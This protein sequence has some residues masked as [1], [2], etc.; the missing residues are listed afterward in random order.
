MRNGSKKRKPELDLELE[1][2]LHTSFVA[3]ANSLSALYTNAISQHKKAHAQGAQAVLERQIAWL[4]HEYGSAQHVPLD[5][6][7][8]YLQHELQNTDALDASCAATA[9]T[10]QTFHGGGDVPMHQDPAPEMGQKASSSP[11]LKSADIWDGCVETPR[12]LQPGQTRVLSQTLSP[13]LAK[14]YQQEQAQPGAHTG[15]QILNTSLL[16]DPKRVIRGVKDLL[17]HRNASDAALEKVLANPPED[18]PVHKDVEGFVIAQDDPR[19]ALRGQQGARWRP[20]MPQRVIPAC[21]VIGFYRALQV[22]ETEAVSEITQLIKYGCPPDWPNRYK[23]AQRVDAY[24][25]DLDLFWPASFQGSSFKIQAVGAG[26]GNITGRINDAATPNSNGSMLPYNKSHNMSRSN[27][28]VVPVVIG[29]WAFPVVVTITD[30]RPGSELLYAY[31]AGYWRIHE[32]N[33]HDIGVWEAQLERGRQLTAELAACKAQLLLL[34]AQVV[35][36]SSLP[37]AQSASVVPQE[38]IPSARHGRSPIRTYIAPCTV[39]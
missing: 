22:A 36:S 12:P 23:W 15:I 4:L 27:V 11:K 7:L 19:I 34:Q 18:V 8:C 16:T 5:V 37:D 33:Q 29:H 20:S 25:V 1:R 6:L 26:Y 2:G 3:A 32:D 38:D 28:T 31:D 14:I 17:A 10:N 21:T 30:M 13:F 35:R 39:Q 9:A 24:S